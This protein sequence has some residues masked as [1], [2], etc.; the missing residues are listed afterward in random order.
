MEH[1]SPLEPWFF[2]SQL[3]IVRD[4][5]RLRCV[6]AWVG[7]SPLVL[8]KHNHRFSTLVVLLDV[9]KL[10]EGCFPF[11]VLRRLQNFDE[12]RPFRSGKV[13]WRLHSGGGYTLC[14]GWE[15]E[16]VH[17]CR[18]VFARVFVFPATC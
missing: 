15:L 9:C 8:L 5:V 6:V 3:H 4:E 18:R 17:T 13:S 1:R 2:S 16:D 12:L 7:F 14:D 10:L 11:F